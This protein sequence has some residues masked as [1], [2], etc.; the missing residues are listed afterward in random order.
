M[1]TEWSYEAKEEYLEQDGV[2]Y[3][4]YGIVTRLDGREHFLYHDV[5]SDKSMAEQLCE[6]LN[7]EA[8]ELEQAKY[9]VED[10]ILEQ[11]LVYA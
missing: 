10:Y 5:T 9:I 4:S 3:T 6:R 8:M 11:Y 1:K 2:K 7:E